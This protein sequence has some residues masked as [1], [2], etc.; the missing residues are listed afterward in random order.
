[1]DNDKQ[2]EAMKAG[3]A[4]TTTQTY[5]MAVVCLLIG[6]AAGYLARG[7]ARPV[8]ISSTPTGT[9]SAVQASTS[10][11]GAMGGAGAMSQVTPDQLRHM[12][13]KQAEPLLAALQKDPNNAVLLAQLGS[14]YFRAQQFPEARQ[15]FERSVRIKANAEV[16][17]SLANTYHYGGSDDQAIATLNRALEVD[18]KSPNALFNLGMLQW[19]V[20]SNPEAAIADWQL[21]LKTNPNHPRRA[22][23]ENMIARAKQHMNMP[24]GTKTNK[25]AM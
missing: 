22:D 10:G 4:W 16:L 21:L 25:P 2:T 17:V 5:V 7:S 3:R 18:P 23:V 6:I 24:A 11:A 1:M 15:Y 14:V 12:A 8:N 20:K 19:Q 9:P 13:D